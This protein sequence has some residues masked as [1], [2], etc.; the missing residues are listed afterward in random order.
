MIQKDP[1]L[2]SVPIADDEKEMPVHLAPF[3]GID[4]LDLLLDSGADPSIETR[5]SG[6]TPL[7]SYLGHQSVE[8]DVVVL[9][10]LLKMSRAN[11]Y[12]VYRR[13]T[14]AQTVLHYA[15]IR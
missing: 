2:V 13:E 8:T 3:A 14:E 7:G 15:V 4:M 11:N 1:G 6:L 5:R 10:R 12:I 9:E